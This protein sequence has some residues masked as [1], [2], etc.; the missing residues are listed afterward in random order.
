MI[1]KIKKRVKAWK[2]FYA[3]DCKHANENSSWYEILMEL[4]YCNLSKFYA[5]GL[6]K[7]QTAMATIGTFSPEEQRVRHIPRLNWI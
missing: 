6:Q 2:R 5:V 7:T 3:Q 4:E 1:E